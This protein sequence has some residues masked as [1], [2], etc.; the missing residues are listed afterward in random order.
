MNLDP[1]D[2]AEASIGR[3]QVV[4]PLPSGPASLKRFNHL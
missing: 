2:F 1:A 3:S 4:D